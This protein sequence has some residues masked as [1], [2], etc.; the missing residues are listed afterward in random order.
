MI[1]SNL[2]SIILL[3]AGVLIITGYSKA[4][5]AQNCK[6]DKN[7]IVSFTGKMTKLAKKIK[8]IYNFNSEGYISL[9]KADTTLSLLL[10]YRTSFSKKVTVNEGA[11]LSF[12]L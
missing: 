10:S 3:L 5:F 11:E 2:K 8:F 1:K 4:L 6:Y 7:E 12:L 9:Q